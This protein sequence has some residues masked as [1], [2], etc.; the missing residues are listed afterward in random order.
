MR[1][2]R[3]G[4]NGSLQ[5]GRRRRRDAAA[6]A[7]AGAMASERG[8]RGGDVAAASSKGAGRMDSTA[9]GGTGRPDSSVGGGALAGA[10]ESSG[11]NDRC[12]ISSARRSET[13]K[14]EWGRRR[15]RRGAYIP[16]L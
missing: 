5:R 16:P 8:A 1:P 15:G 14:C 10:T 6:T 4:D 7:I 9:G 12:S 11:R 3:C 13:A 2:R